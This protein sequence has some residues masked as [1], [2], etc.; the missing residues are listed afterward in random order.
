MR[1]ICRLMLIAI[2]FT[3]IWT[4]SAHAQFKNG[5]VNCLVYDRG[6]DEDGPD[7]TCEQCL[8]KHGECIARCTST[9]FNCWATGKLETASGVVTEEFRASGD[10]EFDALSLALQNCKQSGAKKCKVSCS[11]DTYNMP[12]KVCGPKKD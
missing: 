2:S 3:A 11:E 8:K 4:T 10:H 12:T 5:G 7:S 1:E 6:Y 9:E